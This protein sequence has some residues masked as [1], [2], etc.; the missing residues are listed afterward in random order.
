M[1]WKERMRKAM[2]EMRIACL[3]SREDIDSCN[4]C[5]FMKYCI[6]LDENDETCYATFDGLSW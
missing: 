4:V 5:P 6:A 2:D 3:D 1:G